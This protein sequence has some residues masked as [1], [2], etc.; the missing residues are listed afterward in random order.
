[1]KVRVA[2]SISLIVLFW[3]SSFI[4]I[5]IA[6]QDVSAFEVTLARFVISCVT[7]ALLAVYK[8]PQK[9]LRKDWVKMVMASLSGVTLYNLAL[10]YGQRTISAGSASFLINTV[11]IITTLLAFIFL[12][13]KLKRRTLIGISVSMVGIS[14]ITLSESNTLELNAGILLVLFSAFCQGVF[15]ILQKPLLN[16]YSP[17]TIISWSVWL[18]TLF[19]LPFV[20]KLDTLALASK[21]SL[22]SILFLGIIP[23]AIGH[24]IW[25]F[26]LSQMAAS[27]ATSFLYFVP[28]VSLILSFFLIS[29][30]PSMLLIAGGLITITGIYIVNKKS[31]SP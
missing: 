26:V 2:L 13:E 19:L 10:N 18:G 31:S 7:L 25:S 1:M 30:I 12:K 29:E 3:A 22:L 23:G 14:M 8:R 15:Y 24:V 9:I 27:R 16:R 17:L 6:L 20:G 28:V 5:K 21:A 4:A 11:P